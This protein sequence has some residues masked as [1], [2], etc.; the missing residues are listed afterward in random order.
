M[1]QQARN[2]LLD[3]IGCFLCF[4]PQ[5]VELF[6]DASV[7]L[8]TGV[9]LWKVEWCSCVDSAAL[10]SESLSESLSDWRV[11]EDDKCLCLLPPLPPTGFIAVTVVGRW[12]C[13]IAGLDCGLQWT[14]LLDYSIT[15]CPLYLNCVYHMTST[16]SDVLKWVTC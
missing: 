16:Q 8:H 12:L 7:L 11:N 5:K 10:G 14:G 1:V 3:I 9:E 13:L 4:F 2:M 6:L 15:R